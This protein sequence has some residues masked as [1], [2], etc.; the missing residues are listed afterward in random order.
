MTKVIQCKRC[1]AEMY[2]GMK[3]CPQCGKKNKGPA[4]L[5]VFGIIVLV[6]II[7]A[8][9]GM[10]KKNSE[11]RVTYTWP[12]SELAKLIPEP[13][14]KY[15]KITADSE[16]Y[17]TA[18]FYYVTESDFQD[19]VKECKDN[20]FTVDYM[21]FDSSYM[22]DDASG[23]SLDITYEAKEKTMD[24]TLYAFRETTEETEQGNTE[25]STEDNETE[26][27]NP[28]GIDDENTQEETAGNDTSFRD[29]VDSYEEFMNEYVEF[30]K[31]Y[32]GTN[33]TQLKQYA[34][35]AEEYAEFIKTTDELNE[36]DYSVDDWKYYL[37]AQTRITQKLTE[38]E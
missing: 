14:T 2:K 9:C 38:I 18:E 34:K 36:S 24:V 20:G 13:D 16:K 10:M 11:K 22:A 4:G 15:G 23:N 21:N 17:F 28:S 27:E 1:G 25:I 35:L 7:A 5:I 12:T 26:T 8:T 3:R 37:D 32:D 6:V 19:Y 29:W 31:T 33:V 30:M